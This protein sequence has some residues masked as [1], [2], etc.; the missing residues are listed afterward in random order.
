[1]NSLYIK[2]D[3]KKAS[4]FYDEL[5]IG[6]L[7]PY[8]VKE[9][10][11]KK[12][13]YAVFKFSEDI[14]DV[15]VRYLLYS[16][17]VTHFSLGKKTLKD[18]N[19]ISDMEFDIMD[20]TEIKKYDSTLDIVE[21][22]ETALLFKDSRTIENFC[23]SVKV[24]K[25]NG[26]IAVLNVDKE[27][28]GGLFNIIMNRTNTWSTMKNINDSFTAIAFTI[29]REE[30][31]IEAQSDIEKIVTDTTIAE[32]VRLQKLQ[33]KCALLNDFTDLKYDPVTWNL[34]TFK[35]LLSRL[36]KI[37]GGQAFFKKQTLAMNLSAETYKTLEATAKVYKAKNTY[38]KCSELNCPHFHECQSKKMYST[39][40]LLNDRYEQIKPYQLLS[41]NEAKN[42]LSVMVHDAMQSELKLND[43]A[44]IKVPTSL[45]KTTAYTNWV[46]D[47]LKD[48]S[49]RRINIIAV[50]TIKL[51]L[52]VKADIEKLLKENN[53]ELNVYS[54]QE[55]MPI[56]EDL[57]SDLAESY[58]L[59]NSIGAQTRASKLIYSEV[60]RIAKK[61][62]N[63]DALTDAEK[64][65]VAYSDN[66]KKVTTLG[67]LDSLYIV[68]H[69]WLSFQKDESKFSGRTIIIDEDIFNSLDK[70]SSLKIRDLLVL[71]HSL[72]MKVK[73]ASIKESL[74][75]KEA[76]KLIKNLIE[77]FS[78]E[79]V[80]FRIAD[81]PHIVRKENGIYDLTIV[82]GKKKINLADTL[83]D[84]IL[85][86]KLTSNI[87]GFFE[88]EYYLKHNEDVFYNIRRDLYL[89]RR[90]TNTK[91]T[92]YVLFSATADEKIYKELFSSRKKT[93][94]MDIVFYDMGPVESKGKTLQYINVASSKT[95]LNTKDEDG[96]R[97]IYKILDNIKLIAGDDIKVITNKAFADEQK[98]FLN[99]K[100]TRKYDID[101]VE[102]MYL[103]NT[104]GYN[105]LTGENIA[106]LGG[107]RAPE[108]IT[109]L[110]AKSLGIDLRQSG[111]LK[112][113]PV[114]Y[115]YFRFKFYSY[116]N[117]EDLNHLMIWL[118]DRENV[119]A[120]GRNRN[121]WNNATTI[122]F[123]SI[124]N[125][126]ATIVDTKM[127]ITKPNFRKNTGDEIS[128]D[129]IDDAL[130]DILASIE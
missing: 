107:L 23:S 87:L 16:A 8:T 7:K 101:I 31:S 10:L 19:K 99:R 78:N 96:V 102:D 32:D 122:I 105:D 35:F 15:R 49:L 90:G 65:L 21:T 82:D 47:S 30:F 127:D 4:K 13:L 58:E 74:V 69:E 88:S 103:G 98:A 59:Y 43:M 22:V 86:L 73:Q 54:V 46:I 100:G 18:F 84:E 81:T 24:A 117:N 14:S 36:L 70:I 56:L 108:H 53:L 61:H 40:E 76:Q 2:I 26:H 104:A 39:T 17:L 110:L 55:I 79:L 130:A 44:I 25:L 93:A 67:E 91:G 45:G 62:L 94:S 64:R 80:D 120:A 125:A 115:G 57:N 123:S 28:S 48:Y 106:I 29:S 113:Q 126:E 12:S 89:D 1:M 119:Q 75:L 68:T 128:N 116:E 95:Q 109:F 34:T 111:M 118:I 3:K 51:A 41:V 60:K 42:E 9:T 97:N 63:G 92:K 112:Y 77:H 27:V 66:K 37:Y 20:F 71:E 5:E 121:R 83:I 33:N 50:P 11:D 72:D 38:Y 124:P 85:E 114:D 6:N 52:Q 129:D